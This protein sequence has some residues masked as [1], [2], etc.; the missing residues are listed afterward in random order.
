[1]WIDKTYFTGDIQIKGID[2]EGIVGTAAEANLNQFIT[3]FE[4]EYLKM[5][6]GETLYTA[7]IAGLAVTPTPAARWTALKNKFINST[8]K[9]SPIAEY[10]YY[11]M[12][13]NSLS[14]TT[15]TGEVQP[16]QQNAINVSNVDKQV[17]HYNRA[18]YAA[19][20]IIEWLYANAATYPEFD[21]TEI[22]VIGYMNSF[23]I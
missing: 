5:V 8:T 12:V 16:K 20:I 4:P 19:L 22:K 6:M 23:G 15:Q 21:P 9:S 10:C 3:Q 2:N 1:M 13:R 18:I 14:E 17:L 7:A 11:S